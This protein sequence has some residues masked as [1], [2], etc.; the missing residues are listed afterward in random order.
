M[1]ARKDLADAEA[2]ATQARREIEYWEPLVDAP[3]ADIEAALDQ[4]RYRHRSADSG[5]SQPS[6]GPESTE[7]KS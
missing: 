3:D 5:P 7:E 4:R 1:W 2:K 6:N